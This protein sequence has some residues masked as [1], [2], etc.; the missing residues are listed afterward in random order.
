MS[1]SLGLYIQDN[2]I[3]YAKVNKD[4]DTLKVEA[5]GIKFCDNVIETINQ[6]VAETFSYKTPITTNLTGEEYNYFYMFNLLSKNDLK[7]SIDIEFDSLC[8]DKGINKKYIRNK[9]CFSSR[10][11]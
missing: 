2:L 3:K 4:K 6:I 5:F 10:C 7:K 8:Y 9:I 1:S 11:K